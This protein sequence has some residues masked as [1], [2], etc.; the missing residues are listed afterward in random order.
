MG[1]L[2]TLI[3]L[4]IG[5]LLELASSQWFGGFGNKLTLHIIDS[6]RPLNLQVLFT[7]GE[8]G[9][10]II[11]WDDGGVEKLQEEGKSWEALE[12][13]IFS[14]NDEHYLTKG[15]YNPPFD[16][17]D[18]DSEFGSEDEQSDIDDDNE[19]EEDGFTTGKRRS[20]GDGDSNPTKRRRIN[21]EVSSIYSS[22]AYILLMRPH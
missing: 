2:H 9:E 3:L 19:Y 18:E 7:G 22:C 14:L 6:L 21:R 8:L 4:N 12:A 15:Q 1:Q 11:V 20:L 17:D 13:I 16:S 5:G 10:R